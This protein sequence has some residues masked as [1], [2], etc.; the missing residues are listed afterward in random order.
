MG[1][2][3]KKDDKGKGKQTGT[4]V[5][6]PNNTQVSN[7]NFGGVG[8]RAGMESA[9]KDAFAIPFLQIL[10]KLSPQLD[11][12][13]PVYIEDAEEGNILNTATGEVYDGEEGILVMPV[14][15]K[16]SFTAWTI[17]EKGGGFK[18][19]YQPSD[20]IILT[21]KQDAKNRN[22]LPDGTTQLNDT[23]LHGVILL[24]GDNPTPALISLTSTQIKKSKRWMTAM[25]EKQRDDNAP[26]FAHVY[27]LTTIP[28]RN[29][30]GNW[31]GWKI[32]PAGDVTD[33]EQVDVALAFFK[34]LQVGSVRMRSDVQ[35][36]PDE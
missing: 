7:L 28:E 27:K 36:Q 17:R 1:T 10:Q 8:P 20:P 15:Y 13:N 33:Q 2:K 18:G 23:R 11:K 6:R 21:A 12:N 16:R 22:I 35:Q 14:E 25:Q 24:A 32:E 29:D 19:E 26:T 31:M 34:A 30:Q 3:D 4:A 9:D 5:A